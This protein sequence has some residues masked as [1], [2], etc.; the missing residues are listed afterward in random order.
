MRMV[1]KWF[2]CVDSK[3][4]MGAVTLMKKTVAVG[5]KCLKAVCN[6]DSEDLESNGQVLSSS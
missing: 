6:H 3:Q 5:F 2:L 4:C 1:L